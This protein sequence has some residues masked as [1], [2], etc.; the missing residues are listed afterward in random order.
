M[1]KLPYIILFAILT[2]LFAGMVPAA[3]ASQATG[4]GY[5]DVADAAIFAKATVVI[6]AQ[7]SD[8][9][10][11]AAT[12][13]IVA[14]DHAAGEK[15]F[16]KVLYMA[17]EGNNAW[18]GVVILRSTNPN[19][20]GDEFVMQLQDNGEGASATDMLGLSVEDAEN[21]CGMPDMWVWLPWTYGNVTVN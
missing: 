1:K 6:N 14:I 11:C 3:S 10:S 9:S 5:I 17:V 15:S 2:L 16:G 18:V 19:S 20:I 4:G 21:A 8:T 13:N 12:G 7:Q